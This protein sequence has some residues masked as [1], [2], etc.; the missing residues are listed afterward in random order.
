VTPAAP[1]RRLF[2]SR[3]DSTARVL[4]NE[5]ELAAQAASA[6]FETVVLSELSVAEQ[7]RRFAEASH[8][9][10]PHGAGLANLLFC[11]PGAAVCELHMDLHLHW[12]FRRLAALRGLRYGCLVGAHDQPRQQPLRDTT[13]R[14]DPA[15]LAAVLADPRFVGG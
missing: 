4:V 14:L 11:R 8:V 1:W 3:A 15:A 2:V 9:I 10:A 7:V 13:W 5:V 12:A 6:G